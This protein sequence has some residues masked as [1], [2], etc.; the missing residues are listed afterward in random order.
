MQL[1]FRETFLT[2]LLVK[3]INIGL[4]CFDSLIGYDENMVML[5]KRKHIKI[6][7][8][9]A[10]LFLPCLRIKGKE[11]CIVWAPLDID[12]FPDGIEHLTSYE[13]PSGIVL[14]VF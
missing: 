1:L 8:L 14:S 2:T 6:S 4:L 7:R 11:R 10:P 12:M 9:K 3:S 5:N 13:R